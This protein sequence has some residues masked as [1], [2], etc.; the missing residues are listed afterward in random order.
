MTAPTPQD[1]A[2]NWTGAYQTE[3]FDQGLA[4]DPPRGYGESA[5]CGVLSS[6]ANPSAAGVAASASPAKVFYENTNPTRGPGL[7]IISGQGGGY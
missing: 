1:G 7:N 2:N 3:Q 4:S 5:V 6:L